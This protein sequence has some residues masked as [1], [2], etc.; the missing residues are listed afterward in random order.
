MEENPIDKSG[1][2]NERVK[3]KGRIAIYIDK[4]NSKVEILPIEKRASMILVRGYLQWLD[5]RVTRAVTNQELELISSCAIRLGDRGGRPMEVD[6]EE[7]RGERAP[8][9]KKVL[10]GIERFFAS[11]YGVRDVDL[12][13]QVPTFTTFPKLEGN[14]PTR[15]SQLFRGPNTE[16]DYYSRHFTGSVSGGLV[17]AT[18]QLKPSTFD[19]RELLPHL[20]YGL[21]EYEEKLTLELNFSELPLDGEG[22]YKYFLS[23]RALEPDENDEFEKSLSRLY[24]TT[25]RTDTQRLRVIS[26]YEWQVIALWVDEE[27]V[28]VNINSESDEIY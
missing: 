22:G 18:W 5:E 7:A 24:I 10:S 12:N 13:L 16:S 11:N 25:P 15:M 9:I 1:L 20:G 4:I 28:F 3:V 14:M 26:G 8:G 23:W 2:S 27:G 19:I 6:I 17:R 21:F